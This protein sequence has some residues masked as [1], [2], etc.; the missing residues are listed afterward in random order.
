MQNKYYK[1]IDD[2]VRTGCSIKIF[3]D[4]ANNTITKI[5]KVIPETGESSLVSHQEDEDVASSLFH[6][7][8][9]LMKDESKIPESDMVW[10]FLGLDW[11]VIMGGYT[12]FITGLPDDKI[13]AA[14]CVESDSEC[15]LAKTIIENNVQNAMELLNAVLIDLGS[16]SEESTQKPLKICRLY[17]YVESQVKP[18][19]LYQKS[20]KEVENAY[21][22]M[23]DNAFKDKCFANVFLCG[24]RYPVTRV[25]KVNPG[26]KEYD[27]VSYYESGYVIDGLFGAAKK[28]MTENIEITKKDG[29]FECLGIEQEVGLRGYTLHCMGLSDSRVLA[30][31]C[32]SCYPNYIPLK[33]VIA[34][35]VCDA[36]KLLNHVLLQFDFN[37][38]DFM[39]FA[40]EQSEPVFKYYENKKQ[41][42]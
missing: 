6:T 23:L 10:N 38:S 30:M 13:M 21:C 25:E 40:D 22:K 5:E 29:E 17:E 33:S 31:V 16:A 7:A 12:L 15:V 20:E 34:N 9:K 18:V 19:R 39:R 1:A 35:N 2:V 8:K 27:L 41:D 42:A 26:Q 11:A 32:N 36:L 4:K 24:Q 3:T 28:F 37:T 14:L